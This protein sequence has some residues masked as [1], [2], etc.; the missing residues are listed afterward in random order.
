MHKLPSNYP[1]EDD[2]MVDHSLRIEDDS[3]VNSSQ[4]NTYKHTYIHTCTKK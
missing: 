2:G 3:T 1:I 4:H